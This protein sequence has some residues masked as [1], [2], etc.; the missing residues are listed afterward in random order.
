MALLVFIVLFLVGNLQPQSFT[1]FVMR[2]KLVPV[3]KRTA[4]VQEFLASSRTT[5]LIEN[6]NAAHFVWFGK[7][8]SVVIN[9]DLQRGWSV[10]DTMESISC[11]DSSLFFRSY[12]LP[13]DTRVDYQFIVDGKYGTDPRN[14][15]ITPSGYGAHSELAMPSFVSNHNLVDKPKT[16]HGSIDSLVWTSRDS[17][18]TS[19][20]VWIYKPNGYKNLKNLPTVYV[21]DGNEALQ[22]EFFVTVLDNLIANRAIKPVLAVFVPPVER[23]YEYVGRKQRKFTKA[24]CN[25]LVPLIDRRYHTSRKPDERA[26]MGISNG[27][28]LALATV[29]KRPD[30]FLK[31]AGQSSTMTPQLDEI[32]ENAV[33]HPPLHRPFTL[34]LDVGRYDLDYPGAEESFLKANQG[35]S[36]ELTKDG[37]KHTFRVVNDGHE[38]A[39]WRERTED[40]LDLFFGRK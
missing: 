25:E 6:G 18:L 34:Y 20:V 35:F 17:S 9:G 26:M 23:E 27:G 19:R 30:V 15:R 5:P 40:I 37:I 36:A 22:Y 38:W 14:P 3:E 29:L 24:L 33:E 16:P 28:H 1:A 7:A 12:V 21:H 2:L 39:N 10:P 31:A 8:K 4:V 13:P 32:L 11:G